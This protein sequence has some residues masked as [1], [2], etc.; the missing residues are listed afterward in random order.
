MFVS[1][2]TKQEKV[3]IL[4]AGNFGTCLGQ[5]L[6]TKGLDVTLW[7]RDQHIVEKINQTHQNPKYL[8]SYF[9]HPSIKAC[10][11]FSSIAMREYGVIIIAVPT[12]AIRSV[13]ARIKNLIGHEPIIINTAKGLETS[14]L[15]FPLEIIKDVLGDEYEKNAVILSG[16]SF[17][18]EIIANQPTCVSLASSNNSICLKAQEICHHPFFRAYTS[19]DPVGLEVAGALKNIIAIATGATQGLGYQQNALASL[20]TRGLAEITR[21]GLVLGANPLTFNGLG[22]VGD[23]FLTCSSPKSR[24]FTVGFR[25]AQGH[26]L[27]QVLSEIGSVAEGVTTCKAAYQLAGKFEID[28]PIIQQV[29]NTLYDQ[30]DIKQGMQFLINR[31]PKPEITF[32]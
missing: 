10:A 1:T 4:G 15:F 28:T 20:M 19:N 31:P 21:F 25:V 3:L 13:L 6:A 12:Q 32:P 2:T 11:D 9:L 23:L 22:G 16:P 24:N 7:S 18:A 29:Y 14:T 8:S 27:E 30:Q 5:L 17:A 26:P